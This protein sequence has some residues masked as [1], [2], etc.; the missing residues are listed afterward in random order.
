MFCATAWLGDDG[1]RIDAPGERPPASGATAGGDRAAGGHAQGRDRRA[2]DGS[3]SRGDGPGRLRAAGHEPTRSRHLRGSKTLERTI[4]EART[5]LAAVAVDQE[6]LTSLDA[7]LSA[8]T[9]RWVAAER[10]RIAGR[11]AEVASRRVRLAELIR[12]GKA[13]AAEADATASYAR[14]PLDVETD[15]TA[16]GGELAQAKSNAT[17]AHER[18]QAAV[19]RLRPIRTRRE[20]IA[21]GVDAIGPMAEFGNDIGE[22]SQ[23][24]R[25]ELIAVAGA[26]R[27]NGGDDAREAALR[28]E[29]A[30]TGLRS[31]PGEC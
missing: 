21:A 4:A 26:A 15:V 6:R 1:L 7:T 23:R 27:R 14:F 24:L 29:I 16:L 2:G 5:R 20:V 8:E 28:R 31:S 19:E 30:A 11:L 18:W 3:D 22:R 10:A 9:E 25:G 17:G 12:E 13:Q